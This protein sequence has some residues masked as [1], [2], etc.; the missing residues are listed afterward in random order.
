MVVSEAET[1]YFT[2]TLGQ[3]AEINAR[4]PH[5]FKTVNDFLDWQAEQTPQVEAVGFPIPT[6]SGKAW[7]QRVLSSFM[8][9][10]L[11]LSC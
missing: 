9:P 7:E 5:S 3:A 6:D 11:P 2:C 10:H 8:D 4:N 1:T